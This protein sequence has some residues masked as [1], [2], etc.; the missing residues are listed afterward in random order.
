LDVE[1]AAAIE[2]AY[3]DWDQSKIAFGWEGL[4]FPAAQR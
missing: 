1:E 4:S 3:P 2:Q